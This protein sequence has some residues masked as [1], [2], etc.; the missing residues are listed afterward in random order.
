MF[1]IWHNS[2]PFIL[3][4]SV[5]VAASETLISFCRQTIFS[6]VLLSSLRQASLLGKLWQ[7]ETTGKQSAIPF[8][9]TTVNIQANRPLNKQKSLLVND[10]ACRYPTCFLL[11]EYSKL[12]GLRS[13]GLE[14]CCWFRCW[15]WPANKLCYRKWTES[16]LRKMTQKTDNFS[17]QMRPS[18]TSQQ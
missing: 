10:D 5:S 2:Q 9:Q 6:N 18:P 11:R 3:W 16:G 7:Y 15:I 12:K 1:A 4:I 13:T 17:D 14:Q 8:A